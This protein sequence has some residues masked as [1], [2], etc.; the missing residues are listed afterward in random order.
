MKKYQ[1]KNKA[2]LLKDQ[3][4]V[5]F[6]VKHDDYF[7]TM[8]SILSLLK[9]NIND[10]NEEEKKLMIKVFDNLITDSLYLQANYL[11]TPKKKKREKSPTGKE[12]SQ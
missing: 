10:L 12:I 3:A 4:S 2:W 7:D 9:D 1:L 6:H 11:I 8:A 5:N